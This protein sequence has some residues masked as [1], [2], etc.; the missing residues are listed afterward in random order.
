LKTL[1]HW[2]PTTPI[3]GMCRPTRRRPKAK[4]RADQEGTTITLRD[5]ATDEVPA[6]IK[7][8]R[9]RVSQAR[10]WCRGP[11]GQD[12]PKGKRDLRPTV[13]LEF[14]GGPAAASTSDHLILFGYFTG[15]PLRG[16]G[17]RTSLRG[18]VLPVLHREEDA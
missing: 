15:A 7:P 11:L 6:T 5:R 4:A 12:R 8:T 18:D 17:R 16:M 2:R 1:L 10:R 3:S 13:R 14:A 9:C